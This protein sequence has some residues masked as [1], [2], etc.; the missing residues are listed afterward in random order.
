MNSRKSKTQQKKLHQR[1]DWRLSLWPFVIA[2]LLLW[3]WQTAMSQLMVKTIPYSEFKN[4]L[5]RG[6]I[7]ECAVKEIE[8]TGK[9]QPKTVS[10][11]TSSPSTNSPAT[12][13][14]KSF[15]FRTIR[16]ED[17]KLVEQLQ[18]AGVKYVGVRPNLLSQLLLS[19]L[20]PIALMILAWSFISRK[21]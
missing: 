15:L 21:I 10:A 19:W 20:I 7:A 6:E 17:P 1:P 9:V 11:P 4:Y 3:L 12:T 16:L 8:I 2:F 13:E 14:N 18:A 5:A